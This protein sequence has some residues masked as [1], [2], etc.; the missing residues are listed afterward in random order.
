MTQKKK[1]LIVDDEF[2]VSI[3][4]TRKPMPVY[5]GWGFFV[6]ASRK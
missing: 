3:R 5:P 2:F 1:I 4:N 6:S